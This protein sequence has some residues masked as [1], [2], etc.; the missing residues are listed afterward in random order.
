MPGSDITAAIA[1]MDQWNGKFQNIDGVTDIYIF[2][3]RPGLDDDRSNEF[4]FAL[5]I[6]GHDFFGRRRRRHVHGQCGA[7]KLAMAGMPAAAERTTEGAKSFGITFDL[8][9]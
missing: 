3:A 9:E 1:T 7:R 8:F 2:L 6:G 4:F 5:E